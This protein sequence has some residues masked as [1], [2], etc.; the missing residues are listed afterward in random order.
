MRRKNCFPVSAPTTLLKIA[1]SFNGGLDGPKISSPS[2]A[3]ENNDEQSDRPCG[4]CYAIFAHLQF[5]WVQLYFA[6]AHGHSL[7]CAAKIGRKS[8]PRPRL[9]DSPMGGFYQKLFSETLFWR[10]DFRKMGSPSWFKPV[11]KS[12]KKRPKKRAS[13]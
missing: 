4:R 9:E 1:R 7:N 8:F 11:R 12:A 6:N 5:L 13:Y 3:A 2:G 10:G